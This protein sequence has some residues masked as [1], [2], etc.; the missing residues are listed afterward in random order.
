MPQTS[1]SSSAKCVGNRGPVPSQGIGEGRSAVR[2]NDRG[3]HVVRKNASRALTG[4]QLLLQKLS[5]LN[6]NDFSRDVLVPLFLSMGYERVEFYGG[7][8]ERGRDIV[9]TRR[10]P[11]RPTPYVHLVQSKRIARITPSA[12]APELSRLL[13]Q[14]RQC[15]TGT[16]LTHDGSTLPVDEVTLACPEIVSQRLLDELASQLSN[17][18]RT[19]RIYDGPQIL[20]NIREFCPDLLERFSTV[21][22]RLVALRPTDLSNRELLNV[23]SA[24]NAPDLATFYCD[25]GF[26]VGSVDSHFLLHLAAKIDTN[27]VSVSPDRWMTVASR[28]SEIELRFKIKLTVETIAFIESAFATQLAAFEDPD[29]QIALA[30]KAAIVR[31]I[32]QLR[33]STEAELLRI[34]K[35]ALAQSQRTESSNRDRLLGAVR[36]VSEAIRCDAVCDPMS[37]ADANSTA[38]VAVVESHNERVRAQERLAELEEYVV[39]SPN[40]VLTLNA[41]LIGKVIRTRTTAYL[42]GIQQIQARQT[43]IERIRKFLLDTRDTLA[44]FST[45]R[46]EAFELRDHFR[47]RSS[48]SDDDRISISPHDIFSS[49]LNIAVYGGEGVGKTTTLQAYVHEARRAGRTDVV[50]VPLNAVVDKINQVQGQD[51]QEEKKA[52]PNAFV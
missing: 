10:I 51:S 48:P 15:C 7:V 39:R 1:Y 26:F 13:H 3:S 44:L 33:L 34:E 6:E 46:D 20:A 32:G 30:E 8:L 17:M 35:S 25:L 14:L 40:Y 2:Q 9:A 28:L 24:K 31:Q 22:D 50:Y 43:S 5:A 23:L 52:R 18:P 36:R 42:E 27:P 37:F 49:G 19:V 4:D 47:F 16:I 21:R 38:V 41:D 29:N 11:P 45:L 12:T